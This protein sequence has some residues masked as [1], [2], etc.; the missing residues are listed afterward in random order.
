MPKPLSTI[1]EVATYLRQLATWLSGGVFVEPPKLLNEIADVIERGEATKSQLDE[2]FVKLQKAVKT[3]FCD[4]HWKE[5]L[6]NEIAAILRRG[7]PRFLQALNLLND[8]RVPQDTCTQIIKLAASHDKPDDKLLRMQL[9]CFV[10]LIYVEGVYDAVLRFL[11]AMY[12]KKARTKATPK[13]VSD[14]FKKAKIASRLIEVYSPTIRNAIAH[15]TY[16]LD[17]RSEMATFT[18]L[19]DTKIISFDE[20]TILVDRILHVGIGVS[21]LVMT[22]VMVAIVFNE[23]LK[24]SKKS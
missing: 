11:Y 6:L 13:S 17:T 24:I 19:N 7:S 8:A 21:A 15:A 23:V 16:V 4:E 3:D 18:D 20:L 10:Y 5:E 1:H 12:R 22:Y 2:T 14:N 9:R